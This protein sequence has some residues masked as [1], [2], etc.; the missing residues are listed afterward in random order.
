MGDHL[1]R[2][3]AGQPRSDAAVPVDDLQHAVGQVLRQQLREPPTRARAALTGL[4][5][6]G[7]SGYQRRSEQPGGHRDGI[8]PRGEDGHHPARLRNHQIG[9]RPRAL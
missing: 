9:G 1:D 6:H 3:G 2:R 5:H 8:V 7:V 4:V